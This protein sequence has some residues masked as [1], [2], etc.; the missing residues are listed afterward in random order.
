MIGER[1]IS[2]FEA[3]FELMLES[4]SPWWVTGPAAVALYGAEV[5][6]LKLIDVVVSPGDA[7]LIETR[8]PCKKQRR[9]G[10][11]LLRARSTL[12][13]R[14]ADVPVEFHSWLEVRAGGDWRPLALH[15]RVP[16]EVGDALMPVPP[17]DEL[18]EM[19]ATYGTGKDHILAARLAAL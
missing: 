9:T 13:A 6:T 10:T 14:L 7:R 5:G 15:A 18:A 19:L 12:E 8:L 17:R 1:E 3:L 11:P 4:R 2:A 16:I